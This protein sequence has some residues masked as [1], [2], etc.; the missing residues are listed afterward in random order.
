MAGFD[1]STKNTVTNYMHG[2]RHK[3][4]KSRQIE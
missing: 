3:R 1:L 2:P 4:V